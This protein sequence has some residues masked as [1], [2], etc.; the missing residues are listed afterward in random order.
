MN[1]HNLIYK[2]EI[3]LHNFNT[4]TTNEFLRSHFFSIVIS[5]QNYCWVGGGNPEEGRDYSP[6]WNSNNQGSGSEA[7]IQIPN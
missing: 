5:S 1:N 4:V 3:S 2:L 6:Q 7:Y